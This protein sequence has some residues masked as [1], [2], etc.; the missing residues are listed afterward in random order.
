MKKTRKIGIVTALLVSLSLAS[1]AQTTTSG[2]SSSG[3][4]G[5]E[6]R[7]S[8]GPDA[9]IPLGDF[10]NEYNWNFGGSAQVDIPIIKSLYVTVNAGYQNFFVKNGSFADNVADKNLQL[11]PVKAGLKYFFLGDLLYVQGEAGASFLANKSDVGA[12]NA[13][14]FVYA[15]Q[16]GVLLKLAPKNYIDVGFR[17]EGTSSF[18]NGGSSNNFLGL[19]VAYAFGL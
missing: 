5:K 6:W 2:N 15:P 9:G 19:R 17:F 18:Y 1:Q 13:A 4:T 3:T 7:I 14:A 10:S 8:V 11:I 12:S 16:V